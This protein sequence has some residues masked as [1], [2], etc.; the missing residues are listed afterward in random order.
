[1]RVH[2]QIVELVSFGVGYEPQVSAV[3][4]LL[5]CHRAGYEVAVV[6]PRGE[7]RCLDSFDEFIELFEFLLRGWHA[8]PDLQ[9][10][11]PSSAERTPRTDCYILPFQNRREHLLESLR[12]LAVNGS[13]ILG[14]GELGTARLLAG[15]AKRGHHVTML[16][17]D[18]EVRRRIATGFGI[19]TRVRSV[20]GD[21]SYHDVPRLAFTLRPLRPH[22]VILTTFKKVTISSLAARAVGTPL[23]IQRVVLESDLPK[24][25]SYRWALRHF[26]D[27]VVLNSHSMRDRFI[28]ADPMLDPD[29]VLTIHDGV[30]APCNDLAHHSLRHE[31]NIPSDAFVIGSVTRMAKQ[32]RLDRIIH[33]M[34]IL[35]AHV[36]CVLAGEGED[37]QALKNIASESKVSDRVH[38]TGFRT[39]VGNVLNS[40]D[41]FVVSSNREGM[42]NA[43]LEAMQTGL[44][45]VSTDVSGAREALES[46]CGGQC[47]GMV[48][49]HEPADIATA[50]A[51]LMGDRAGIFAMGKAAKRRAQADFTEER[52]LDQWESLLLTS[53]RASF[54]AQQL[55]RA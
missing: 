22:V 1:M 27:K 44:P 15:L 54:T 29:K 11:C 5:R 7:H 47:A 40:M 30:A 33:A 9:N 53:V 48:V 21:F 16:L 55:T 20:G 35:P 4:A 51:S 34:R 43:M 25:R 32:K 10:A 39:D 18:G 17:G 26:V 12:I 6:P 8:L 41:L 49:G 50:I 24:R 36:H 28:S 42:A 23:V 45:V 31:L 14:G 37:M 2:R 19:Q 52:F 3:D 13:H 46:Q 38:F